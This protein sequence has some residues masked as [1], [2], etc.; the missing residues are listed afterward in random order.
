M[1]TSVKIAFIGAALL[2]L[3]SC[4]SYQHGAYKKITV[5]TAPEAAL[6]KIYR[7]DEGFIKSIAT[8]GS[9]YIRRNAAPIEIVCSKDGY[10][11]KSV[12][13]SSSPTTDEQD[14]S[15]VGNALFT[16]VAPGFLADTISGAKY[17]LP[18]KIEITLDRD[19]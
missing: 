16:G 6:C 3:S 13:I 19:A 5:T 12:S 9:K 10:K 1:H 8:P 2:G 18:D 11:T 14:T 17:D 15:F 7:E 4:A